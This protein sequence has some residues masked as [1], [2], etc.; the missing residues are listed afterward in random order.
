M[1]NKILET[2]EQ[3]AIWK[4]YK[5]KANSEQ[6]EFI[7]KLVGFAV[8]LLQKYSDTFPRYTEHSGKHQVNILNHISNLLGK[9][10]NDLSV[11]ECAI[12]I[13][14]TFFHDIG[15]V[16][17]EEDRN[18]LDGEADFQ[19]FIN[20]NPQANLNYLR[21]EKQVNQ[22]LAEWF[23]RWSHASRVCV[24]LKAIDKG[25]IEGVSLKWQNKT[26]LHTKLGVVCESH[27]W[28]T[29]RLKEREFDTLFLGEADL[30]LCAILLRLGDILD[31][32]DTRTEESIF[33]YY[34]KL[35][36]AKYG[37]ANYSRKEWEKHLCSIGFQFPIADRRDKPYDIRFIASPEHPETE[38][39]VNEFL[40]Y[41]DTEIRK[42]R[43]ILPFCSEKWRTLQLPNTIKREIH[44]QNYKSGAF[45]FTLDQ[46]QVLNLLMGENLYQDTYVCIRELLQNAIDTSRHREFYERSKGRTEFKA[47]AIKVSEWEDADGYQWIRFDDFGMG[48]NEKIIKNYFLKVGNSYY[49]SPEFE[50]E[51]IGYKKNEVDFTPISRFGIG[52]LSCFLIAD[53]VEVSSYKDNFSPLKLSIEGI[54]NY[55]ILKIKNEK[56]H[57]DDFPSEFGSEEYRNKIGTSIAIRIDPLKEN[58]DF[59]LEATLKKWLFYPSVSVEFKGKN[60]GGNPVLLDEPLFEPFAEYISDEEHQKLEEFFGE[61][62]EGKIGLEYIPYNLTEES[63]DSNLKGQ[64]ILIKIVAPKLIYSE[65]EDYTYK[66]KVKINDWRFYKNRSKFQ[67]NAFDEEE[68]L[69]L[70]FVK[71]VTDEKGQSKNIEYR[72]KLFTF[73]DFYKKI[74]STFF[75]FKIEMNHGDGNILNKILFSHNGIYCSKIEVD[76]SLYTNNDRMIIGV[77]SLFDDLRPNM[78]VSRNENLEFG[79]EIKNA[80]QIATNTLWEN[81][82]HLKKHN[83]FD[84]ELFGSH[85]GL[86]QFSEISIKKIVN[87]KHLDFWKDKLVFDVNNQLLPF[88]EVKNLLQQ[89]SKNL[90]IGFIAYD[91]VRFRIYNVVLQSEFNIAYVIAEDLQK[92]QLVILNDS[93]PIL[94]EGLNYFYGLYFVNFIGSDKLLF[95]MSF[96]Q[97][98]PFSTW[99]ID[100]YTFIGIN[101]EGYLLKILTYLGDLK[102]PFH[103]DPDY[104]NK[105]IVS[106]NKVLIRLQKVISTDS[107]H[108]PKSSIFLK[109]D[110][111]Y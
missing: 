111:F 78:Q 80:I 100:S 9:R 95:N 7:K 84:F 93:K 65:D 52:I 91:I 77:I 56:H 43:E 28:T 66:N 75:S 16:F 40:D 55:Y 49:N 62:L 94:L 23:C 39:G 64:L 53:K 79:F 81:H 17:S 76:H 110:D 14:S 92:S 67:K 12:L 1:H 22:D 3:T 87:L 57:A 50:A 74:H 54:N 29:E 13:L 82:L 8:P 96:N 61:K 109:K 59:N 70:E 10:L 90:K 34:L 42:C 98:H 18:K 48:M 68:D 11:L 24:Y 30:R 107:K 33:K 71:K 6:Q 25:K 31:F 45:N 60:I 46:K 69:S 35:D 44:S 102:R 51:K 73:N 72:I 27:N 97:S 86:L 85:F 38:V 99:L 5:R 32:D 106:I 108:F 2:Y 4:I 20:E 58:I 89:G 101:H 19:K 88:I 26:S 37:S 15:M 47:E 83:H 63:R 103:Q 104:L 105:L 41:I 36:K 21:N